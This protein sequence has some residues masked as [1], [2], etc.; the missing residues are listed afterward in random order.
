MESLSVVGDQQFEEFGIAQPVL[1][2]YRET[3]NPRLWR[4]DVVDPKLLKRQWFKE[5]DSV[6][7]LWTL[8]GMK[9]NCT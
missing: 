2:T 3:G 6:T 1:G 7:I 8:F 9:L 4:V 5:S